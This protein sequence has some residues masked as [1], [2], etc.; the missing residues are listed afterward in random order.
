MKNKTIGNQR[1]IYINLRS[2]RKLIK[3]TENWKTKKHIAL[4]KER[5]IEHF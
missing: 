3:E 4:K 2:C 5:T 1:V